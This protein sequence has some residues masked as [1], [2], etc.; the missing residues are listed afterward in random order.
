MRPARLFALAVTAAL[1]AG[2]A[3]ADTVS[4]MDTN[5]GTASPSSPNYTL[6]TYI[7][8]STTS[9]PN[10]A[11]T[12]HG[13]ETTFQVG[14]GA[15]GLLQFP[16]LFGSG[17]GQIPVGATIVSATLDLCIPGDGGSTVSFSLVKTPWNE[18]TTWNTFGPS[19]GPQAGVDYAS[20]PFLTNAA[21]NFAHNQYDFTAAVQAW[22]NGTANNGVLIQLVSGNP[23]AFASSEWQNSNSES[24]HLTV[25]YTPKPVPAP[26]S[27]V[28]AGLAAGGLAFRRVVR[29]KSAV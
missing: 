27:A 13:N 18:S 19:P 23:V 4:F 1:A 3:R 6:D 9:N 15:V 17:P 7:S 21:A 29:R 2:P 12:A 16:N 10:G 26:P 25:T 5:Y 20:T 11:N 14:G 24:P 28:L 22:A 8:P